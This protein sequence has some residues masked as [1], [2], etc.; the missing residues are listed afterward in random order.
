MQWHFTPNNNV[1]ENTNLLLL[2]EN[3]TEY[4][5]SEEVALYKFS[6]NLHVLNPENLMMNKCISKCSK[7]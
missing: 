2:G 6:F 4:V 1:W 3:Q 7:A 5:L